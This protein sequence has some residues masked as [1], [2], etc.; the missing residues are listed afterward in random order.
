M[1]ME[2]LGEQVS[3]K[4]SAEGRR[5]GACFTIVV[6]RPRRFAI[7]QISTCFPLGMAEPDVQRSDRAR[8]CA[9]TN[10]RR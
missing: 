1:A 4:S 10:V 9:L 3:F 8:V 5:E 2:S 7:L 6:P